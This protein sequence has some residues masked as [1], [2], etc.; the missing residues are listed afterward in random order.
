MKQFCRKAWP[1][2]L[3]PPPSSSSAP[4]P[5]PPY[6]GS[7]TKPG[8]PMHLYFWS[9]FHSGNRSL[10][11]TVAPWSLNGRGACPTLF[12]YNRNQPPLNSKPSSITSRTWGEWWE[13]LEYLAL[14]PY[15]DRSPTGN[16]SWGMAEVNFSS[17]Y[18]RVRYT[19]RLSCFLGFNTQKNL[20]WRRGRPGGL[21]GLEMNLQDRLQ[22]DLKLLSESVSL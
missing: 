6:I 1:I 10:P 5:Q 19:V 3:S 22:I 18:V 14:K 12:L 15:T 20:G 4:P 7:S 21:W 2:S 11:F 17:V 16:G 9:C 8:L 13:S